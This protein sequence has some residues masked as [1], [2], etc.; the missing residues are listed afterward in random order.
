MFSRSILILMVCS[1]FGG[2]AVAQNPP[3][4]TASPTPYATDK[5]GTPPEKV[6]PVPPV[7]PLYRSNERDI[8]ELNRVGVDMTDQRPLSLNDS[9]VM[10]LE[11]NRDIEVSRKNV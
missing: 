9:I 3:L 4:P 10:A 1:L 6:G 2:I 11:N 8:P 5:T 7:A